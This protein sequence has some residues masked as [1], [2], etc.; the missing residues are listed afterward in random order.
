MK[1]G[2]EQPGIMNKF[3]KV[4]PGG[5]QATIPEPVKKDVQGRFHEA[6]RSQGDGQVNAAKE[7]GD[8]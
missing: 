2:K 3:R 4:A 7:P 5:V 1:V 8:W 6:S